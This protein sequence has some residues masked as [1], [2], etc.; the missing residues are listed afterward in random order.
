MN[1]AAVIPL[2][3]LASLFAVSALLPPAIAR[4]IG[5]RAGERLAIGI[6]AVSGLVLLLATGLLAAASHFPELRGEEPRLF[7]AAVMLMGVPA[8]CLFPGVLV[9]YIAMGKAQT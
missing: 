6:G 4:Y 2:G 8:L 7:L 1:A 9:G 3:V 5:Y